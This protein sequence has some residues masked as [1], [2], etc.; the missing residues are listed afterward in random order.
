MHAPPYRW[1]PAYK[2]LLFTR[3]DGHDVLRTLLF[4][5]DPTCPSM[6]RHRTTTTTANTTGGGLRWT[7]GMRK[8]P[9]FRTTVPIPIPTRV[10]FDP[11]PTVDGI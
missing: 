9:L 4:T 3:Q 6:E 8:A 1:A 10:K 11:S 7:R 2:T 5:S